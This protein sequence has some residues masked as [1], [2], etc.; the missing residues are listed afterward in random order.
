MNTRSQ[1]RLVKQ[2]VDTCAIC[3]DAMDNLQ[4]VG[5]MDVCDHKFHKDCLIK[6]LQRKT[7]CPICR[8]KQ[9]DDETSDDSDDGMTSDGSDS[10]SESDSSSDSDSSSESEFS[11]DS[12]FSSESASRDPDARIVAFFLSQVAKE[13]DK[14]FTLSWLRY[15]LRRYDIES[16]NMTR[17]E[18]AVQLAEKLFTHPIDDVHIRVA[19]ALSGHDD[20]TR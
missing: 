14:R 20:L 13:F 3:L 15:G 19:A 4:E 10:S 11:S 16:N 7:S 2:R 9:V 6:A 5:T 17:Y 18:M 12:E 8:Q 1:T